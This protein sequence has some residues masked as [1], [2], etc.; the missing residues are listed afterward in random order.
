VTQHFRKVT[1]DEVHTDNPFEQQVI[2]TL[3]GVLPKN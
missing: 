3:R 2:D 1:I